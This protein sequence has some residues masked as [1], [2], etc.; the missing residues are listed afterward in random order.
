[1]APLYYR[2]AKAAVVVF[3]I[4]DDRTFRKAKGWVDELKKHVPSDVVLIVCANKVDMLEEFGGS[5]PIGAVSDEELEEYVT[6]MGAELFRTSAKSNIGVD[7][8][9]D[10]V[11][12]KLLKLYIKERETELLRAQE[13]RSSVSGRAPSP[14]DDSFVRRR[15][16]SLNRKLR[17]GES[18][19]NSRRSEGCC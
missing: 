3:D 12:Q 10:A 5:M 16:D 6:D 2:N 11:A 15:G 4:T 19:T 13:H 8:L 1:M 14:N 7:G 9:F 18:R 17:I